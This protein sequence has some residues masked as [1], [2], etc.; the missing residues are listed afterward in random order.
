LK[1]CRCCES[2]FASLA[3]THV[4]PFWTSNCLSMAPR[5]FSAVDRLL[6]FAVNIIAGSPKSVKR[7]TKPV[8]RVGALSGETENSGE[9]APKRTRRS[10][11]NDSPRP[12]RENRIIWKCRQVLGISCG[13]EGS[14]RCQATG[15]WCSE[16]NNLAPQVGFEH[17]IPRVNRRFG[18]GS[19]LI[20]RKRFRRPTGFAGLRLRGPLARRADYV[21]RNLLDTTL[22][23]QGRAGPAPTPRLLPAPAT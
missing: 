1:L 6:R 10:I 9:R 13:S 3:T 20:E 19:A 7:D 5:P 8:N 22:L 17:T 18:L 12:E 23:A 14:R 21:P 11:H 2:G 15:R 4:W 16:G